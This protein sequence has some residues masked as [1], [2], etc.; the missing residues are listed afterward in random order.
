[1]A[2]EPHSNETQ[3]K[4]E[5]GEFQVMIKSPQ[6]NRP[7]GFCDGDAADEAEIHEQAMHEG[8]EVEI[9]K[10]LLKTGREIWTVRPVAEI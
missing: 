10:K 6:S 1:M 8:A 2:I 5:H 9:D 3:T 4:W 7:I